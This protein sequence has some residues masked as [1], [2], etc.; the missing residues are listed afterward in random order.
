MTPTLCEP[1]Y[2][3]THSHRDALQPPLKKTLLERGISLRKKG[4]SRD[5]AV[6]A[7]SLGTISWCEQVP[8]S[9]T[10]PPHMPIVMRAIWNDHST[11]KHRAA[12]FVPA[13][14]RSCVVAVKATRDVVACEQLVFYRGARCRNSAREL[15]RV[16]AATPKCVYIASQRR[17]P[18]A[19]CS[20]E[21]PITP[22]RA[23]GA[24]PR[25]RRQ[26]TQRRGRRAQSKQH[27]LHAAHEQPRA[28]SSTATQAHG[29]AAP[30]MCGLWRWL[31]GGP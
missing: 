4:R 22:I 16:D 9:C 27:R 12:D 19:R 5:N 15:G 31:P 26:L 20:A 23:C 13:R 8:A 21:W 1:L 14:A 11:R 17:R 2:R 10:H 3:H 18:L 30:S 25:S 29:A 7:R 28:S 24:S 6:D